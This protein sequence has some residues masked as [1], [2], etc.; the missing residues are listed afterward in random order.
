G[1]RFEISS[2]TPIFR[3]ERYNFKSDP[4]SGGKI[5]DLLPY[6]TVT[7][8]V[9]YSKYLILLPDDISKY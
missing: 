1:V 8:F 7:E 2:L 4:G 9:L 3:P 5:S 6:C